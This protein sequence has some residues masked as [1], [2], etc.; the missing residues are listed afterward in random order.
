MSHFSNASAIVSLDS[1]LT[2]LIILITV[3]FTLYLTVMFTLGAINRYSGASVPIPSP[4]ESS[5][6]PQIAFQD[7][8]QPFKRPLTS[9][10]IR[11]LKQH[12]KEAHIPNYSR[13]VKLQL[14]V[15]LQAI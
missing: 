13:M 5:S 10:T 15:A 8:I 6:P 14:I 12:A 11:Q 4:C 2:I 3:V 9:L 1:F 7:T